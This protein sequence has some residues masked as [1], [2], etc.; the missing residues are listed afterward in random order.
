ME[1]WVPGDCTGGDRVA[2]AER[3]ELNGG[4][5]MLNVVARQKLGSSFLGPA[6]QLPP[7]WVLEAVPSV[8]EDERRGCE[9]REGGGR[10][11]AAGIGADEKDLVAKQRLY[12][13][14]LRVDRKDDDRRL[15]LA[16]PDGVGDRHGVLTEQ[17]Q[18]YVGMLGGEFGNQLVERVIGGV[19]GE[20]DGNERRGGR[21]A[22]T[23]RSGRLLRGTHHPL[24]VREEDVAIRSERHAAPTAQHKHGPE[25]ALEAVDLVGDRGLRAPQRPRRGVERAV[26]S[27]R[28]EAG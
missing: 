12:R 19:A 22:P 26:L 15:E 24:S 18:A 2:E 21:G 3:C 11:N 1:L 28:A 23:N 20:P 4:L 14:P 7:R 9:M 13:Q 27:G 25:L 10:A 5:P 6:C 16:R 8:V 17:P